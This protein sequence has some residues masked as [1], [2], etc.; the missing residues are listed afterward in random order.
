MNRRDFLAAFAATGLFAS[1]GHA[2]AP[3]PVKFRRQPPYAHALAMVEPGLDEFPA[4]KA[5]LQVEAR[6]QTAFQD[7][8]LPC[9]PGCRGVSPKPREYRNVAPGVAA[10]VFGDSGDAA[11]GWNEWRESLGEV[12]KARF[13]SLPGDLIRY[14]VRGSNRG[15]LEHRVGWWKQSWQRRL[16]HQL[17]AGVGNADLF[18]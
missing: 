10:A 17:R 13:F 15:R 16:A 9:A 7:G 12:R 11:S 3:F 8:K 18:G 2:S 4:E 1:K 5:A 6:L 14:D